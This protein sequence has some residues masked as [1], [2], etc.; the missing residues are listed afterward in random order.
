[1]FPKNQPT[2][3]TLLAIAMTLYNTGA[4]YRD[5][6]LET[7]SDASVSPKERKRL[8]ERAKMS[9]ESAMKVHPNLSTSSSYQLAFLWGKIDSDTDKAIQY[10]QIGLDS[11]RPEFEDLKEP[12]IALRDELEHR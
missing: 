2:E 7:L 9:F 10:C 5:K 11:I 6:L 3:A 4:I 1:M 8:L 12:I